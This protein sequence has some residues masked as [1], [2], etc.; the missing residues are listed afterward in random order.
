M[1][2]ERIDLKT[3]VGDLLVLNDP[4]WIAS[5][6][7]TTN[8]GAIDAWKQFMP[9]A[10]TLKSCTKNPE[11][12]KKQ[13]IHFRLFPALQRFG[14]STYCDGPKQIEL[15][16]YEVAAELLDYAKENLPNTKVGLS[17]LARD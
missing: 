2:I 1:R 17:V 3:K 8:K 10:V 5:C 12:E 15:L 7:L 4:F 9:A 14:R 6:H 13:Q 11:R 16:S